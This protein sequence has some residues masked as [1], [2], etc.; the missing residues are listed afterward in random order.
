[1]TEQTVLVTPTNGATGFATTISEPL[2]PTIARQLA[3]HA[4]GWADVFGADAQGNA[5]KYIVRKT[6]RK[7]I[8]TSAEECA[9]QDEE[10]AIQIAENEALLREMYG[11]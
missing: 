9:K 1:M 11:V 8:E 4:G 10:E 5:V 2:T 3:R 7:V 6:V